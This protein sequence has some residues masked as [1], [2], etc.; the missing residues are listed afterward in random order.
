MSYH[1]WSIHAAYYRIFNPIHCSA[2][3]GQ[4]FILSSHPRRH[5]I[6]TTLFFPALS[7]AQELSLADK[8]IYN[9]IQLFA[10]SHLFLIN[11]EGVG[12]DFFEWLCGEDGYI[13]ALDLKELWLEGC[14]RFT[15]GALRKFIATRKAI[16][17]PLVAIKVSGKGPMISRSDLAWF[18]D[19]SQTTTYVTW[20]VE[21]DIN[22]QGDFVADLRPVG[23]S[24]EHK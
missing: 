10:F 23:E 18:L 9:V 6:P 11:C 5:I 24:T 8:S 14:N 20:N 1:G 17:R 19:E 12:D 4:D 7:K 16:G 15:S 3:S 2:N 22:M 13:P 21:A